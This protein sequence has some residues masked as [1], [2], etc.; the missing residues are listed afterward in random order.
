MNHSP[1]KKNIRAVF[2]GSILILLVGGSFI[3]RS[4][5]STPPKETSEEDA[6]INTNKNESDIP[7]MTADVI[8]Q[9]ILNGEP[10]QFLEIRD[11]ESYQSEH[12]PHS[13][14][15]SSGALNSFVP[16]KNEIPVIV[17]S[18]KDTQGI[19]VVKNV[20]RQK[21]YNA[22][23][24][25]GGFEEWQQKGNQ[26]ISSGNQNSFLDQSKITY[27]T[28][29]EVL[30]A[31][32]SEDANLIILDVQPET[33]YRKVHIKGAINIPLDSL[34]KRSQEIP[35]GKNIIV[36]GETELASFQ[37]GVRLSDLNFFAT[38]TLSNAH[39]LEKESGL[40]LEP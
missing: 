3:F 2:I 23:L 18:N 24:L 37:G 25:K 32:N 38:K 39:T 20:L 1:Q 9:K 28:P 29:P 10:I 19:E 30:K 35:P 16:E 34:E 22:F 5:K 26:I 27:I 40:P 33:S 4:L 15:L 13:L 6:V 11:Q 36:Y 12:I 7:T 14:L 17:L 8:R 31:M 21:S